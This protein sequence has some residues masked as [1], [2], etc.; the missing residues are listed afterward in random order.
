MIE[1]PS[2]RPLPAPSP[3][4]PPRPGSLPGYHRKK[5]KR[6]GMFEMSALFAL[7]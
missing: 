7:S 1:P 4:I 6:V 2:P 5:L 3:Y